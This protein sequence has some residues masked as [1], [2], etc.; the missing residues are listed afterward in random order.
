MEALFISKL[1]AIAI[2]SKHFK[3]S[4]LLKEISTKSLIAP[5]TNVAFSVLSKK[6]FNKKLYQDNRV[7]I[8]MVPI[9]DG[10]TLAYKK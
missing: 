8:S 10:L 7:S 4:F 6:S 3:K 5:Q 9:G 1:F 2:I